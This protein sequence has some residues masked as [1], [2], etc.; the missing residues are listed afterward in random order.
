MYKAKQGFKWSHYKKILFKADELETGH[1]G[2]KFQ[3]LHLKVYLSKYVEL[4]QFT[5]AR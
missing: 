1:I 5:E 4:D 3:Q 2:T